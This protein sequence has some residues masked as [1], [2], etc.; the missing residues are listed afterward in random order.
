MRSDIVDNTWIHYDIIIMCKNILLICLLALILNEMRKLSNFRARAQSKT[1]LPLESRLKLWTPNNKIRSLK[2]NLTTGLQIAGLSG[3]EH[4]VHIISIV[5]LLTK[6]T[7]F[8]YYCV[9]SEDPKH[10]HTW[11]LKSNE[12]HYYL[13]ELY[14]SCILSNNYFRFKRCL[15][16]YTFTWYEYFTTTLIPYTKML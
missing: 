12:R 4:D 13:I 16:I 2:P 14:D 9:L 10:N 15:I 6:A 5:Y 8:G 7:A 11:H 3:Q 1:G